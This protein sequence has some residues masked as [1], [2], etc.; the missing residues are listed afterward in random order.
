M[1]EDDNQAAWGILDTLRELCASDGN[2]PK[3]CG[4]P[5]MITE[6]GQYY[7]ISC[8]TVAGGVIDA[9]AEWRFFSDD[10][11]GEDPNRCGMPTN[12]LLPKS[13]LGSVIG[14][15]GRDNK[16]IRQIRMYQLWNSMPYWER[17][18]Y[19]NFD[20]VTSTIANHNIPAKVLDDAK[21]LI[22][23][24]SERKISRGDNKEGVIASCIYFSCLINNTPRSTKEI[25]RM[26]HI[27]Q[28]VLT[29]G[30]ARFQN[31]L[32]IN[33]KSTSADDF[34]ARFGSRMSMEY[35]DIQVC[36]RIATRLEDLDIVSE[37]SPTSIAA[38]V[39]HYHC[40][41]RKLPFTKPQIAAACEVSAMTITKCYKR[42]LKWSALIDGH[43]K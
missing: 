3:C 12:E 11:R 40:M 8:S 22:K 19:G 42:I 15:G 41:N 5:I 24:V 7:C 43:C 17:S 6:D 4:N 1:Q 29:K 30:N 21:V 9:G 18:L 13:S 20:R 32:K 14:P 2:K 33:V 38:A 39:L 31:L 27:D 26:F 23:K 16:T 25:A 36:K 37:N 35:D 34:V 10:C 28:N